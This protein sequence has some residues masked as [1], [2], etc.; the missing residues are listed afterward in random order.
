MSDDFMTNKHMYSPLPAMGLGVAR[1]VSARRVCARAA[2]L[3]ESES[4]MMVVS[5]LGR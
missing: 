3:T 4:F 2:N 5:E 1:A